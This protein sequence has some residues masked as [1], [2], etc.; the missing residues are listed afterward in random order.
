LTLIYTFLERFPYYGGQRINSVYDPSDLI[1]IVFIFSLTGCTKQVATNALQDDNGCIERFTLPV[2]AHSL[3][4]ND[5][6]TIHGLYSANGI[7]NNNLRY[8][9]YEYSTFQPLYPPNV[10]YD[11][12]V[13]RVDQYA[14]GVRIF[15]GSIN[16]IFLNNLFHYRAGDLTNGTS[17]D[18]GSEIDKAI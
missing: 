7:N 16:Y 14:N 11:E 8:Y 12:K 15:T 4:V 5:I 1:V 2:G 3:S 9:R 13:V 17:L 18:T 10:S 6:D